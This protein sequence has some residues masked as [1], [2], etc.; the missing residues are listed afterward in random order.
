MF[1]E[2]LEERA[3]ELYRPS[4]R[5]EVLLDLHAAAQDGGDNLSASLLLHALRE[6]E[7]L[8]ESFQVQMEKEVRMEVNPQ[9]LDPQRLTADS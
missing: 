2:R 1:R 8:R 4:E 5:E 3:A 7:N 6:I 9:R